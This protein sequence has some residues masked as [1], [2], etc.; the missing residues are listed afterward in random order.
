M[1]SLEVDRKLLFALAYTMAAEWHAR[2]LSSVNLDI[3]KNSRVS[4][5]DTKPGKDRVFN[6][7]ARCT[8]E[9]CSTSS[10]LLNSFENP[11]PKVLFGD[12]LRTCP[13]VVPLGRRLKMATSPTWRP[14]SLM[15]MEF[16]DARNYTRVCDIS[17]RRKG[18][19]RT[20]RTTAICGT[21]AS[22]VPCGEPICCNEDGLEEEGSG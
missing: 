16:C 5:I 6:Y 20:A 15:S 1:F 11:N 22:T 2:L 9:T 17:I 21:Q 8:V 12:F 13:F 3:E 7:L 4:S 19:A 18:S 14:S 10:I